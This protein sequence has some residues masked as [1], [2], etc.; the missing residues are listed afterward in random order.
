MGACTPVERRLRQDRD[1]GS[2]GTGTPA[3]P[4][5]G[6]RFPGTGTPAPPG[7]GRRRRR[8]PNAGAT[9]G[10]PARYH[11]SPVMP[12]AQTTALPVEGREAAGSRAARRLRRAGNVP[13][14]LYGGGEEPVAFQVD[15]RL[16]R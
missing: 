11:H 5:P 7:P 15:A 13:G 4:G 3:P 12:T 10:E 2:T 9:A 8:A 16:L 1:A 6:R 14:V